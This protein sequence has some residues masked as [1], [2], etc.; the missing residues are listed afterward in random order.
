MI[1]GYMLLVH[2]NPGQVQRLVSAQPDNSPVLIHVD[3]RT[4]DDFQEDLAR[5]LDGRANVH[6]VPRFAS[7][8]GSAGIMRATFSLIG[9]AIE[10]GITFDYATLLSG[11]DYP[12]KSNAEIARFLERHQG[13][14][15]IESFAMEKPNRWSAMGGNYKAP[16]KV[17]RY[18][19]RI[20]SRVMRTPFSRRLP[21]GLVAYGGSQ[22]WTLSY[23]ALQ[24]IS[25]FV[26][27]TPKF[28]RF[29]D[30]VFIPDE[31]AIQT[32]LS[33]SRFADRITGDDLRLAIWD[34]PTPPYPATLKCADMDRIF[35]SDKFFARKFDTETDAEVFDRIDRHRDAAAASA[36]LKSS[37]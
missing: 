3:R 28:A 16:D 31:F 22:W 33:N 18:H 19:L 10:Q 34:R 15:F 6:F 8:W 5:R 24:H 26:R 27:R 20:R 30:G 29:L 25:Q 37:H 14:E 13:S 21:Y 9:S 11:A 17:L 4:P 7:R 35:D 12:I 23:A 2:E 32:I 1:V 36:R